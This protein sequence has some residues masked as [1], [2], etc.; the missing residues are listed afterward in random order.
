MPCLHK[1]PG[2]VVLLDTAIPGRHVLCKS[3][4]TRLELEYDA[5][6]PVDD[7]VPR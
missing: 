2:M 3:R 7:D 1:T 4:A 5:D 6:A